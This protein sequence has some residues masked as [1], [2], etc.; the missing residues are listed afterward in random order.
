M[1]SKVVTENRKDPGLVERHP[2]LDPI[3]QRVGDGGGVVAEIFGEV[4]IRPSAGVLERLRQIP[5]IE[6]HPRLDVALEHL[7]HDAI[8]EVESLLINRAF[9]GRH[10]P[11]P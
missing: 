2:M 4:A 9:P 10:D 6:R 11:R 7:V 5:M 3:A 1:D 8:V